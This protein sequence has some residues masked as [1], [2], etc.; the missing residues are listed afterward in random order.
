[1]KDG[2]EECRDGGG[3]SGGGAG[4]GQE[5]E[6]KKGQLKGGRRSRSAVKRGRAA[7]T[8]CA[9]FMAATYHKSLSLMEGWVEGWGFDDFKE[10]TC[11]TRPTY[12][13]GPA[14]PLNGFLPTL[15]LLAIRCSQVAAAAAVA[16][17]ENPSPKTLRRY[18]RHRLQETP[19]TSQTCSRF[20]RLTNRLPLSGRRTA[21]EKERPWVVQNCNCRVGFWKFGVTHSFPAPVN[22]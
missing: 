8:G 11:R 14:E 19:R 21:R 12:T 5:E 9:Y 15:K 18:N 16:A 7:T 13:Q 17:L 22:S 10:I 2:E 3:D 4:G 1:M 6:K 20:I